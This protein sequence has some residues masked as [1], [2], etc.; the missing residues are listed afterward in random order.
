MHDR[1]A[2]ESEQIAC[3]FRDPV[4]CSRAMA[5][6]SFSHSVGMHSSPPRLCPEREGVVSSVSR[7]IGAQ[8]SFA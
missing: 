7:L 5:A 6:A 3:L 8:N 2:V 1:A 4:R